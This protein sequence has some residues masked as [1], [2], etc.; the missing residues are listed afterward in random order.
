MDSLQNMWNLK[1]DM[2]TPISEYDLA[3]YTHILYSSSFKIR[4]VCLKIQ[5]SGEE[6]LIKSDKRANLPF[7]GKFKSN[8]SAYHFQ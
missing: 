3:F 7:L 5:G 1:G 8:S 6:V 2:P 4:T